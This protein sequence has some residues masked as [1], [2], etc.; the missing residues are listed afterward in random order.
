MSANETR[1][2]GLY[3]GT[4]IGIVLFALVGLL[5]GSMIGGVAGLKIAG[6]MLGAPLQGTLFARLIVAA[7]MIMGVLVAAVVFIFGMG[8]LGWIGGSVVETLR[9]KRVV[10]VEDQLKSKKAV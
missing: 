8:T 4:G 10:A 7:G 5:P 3:I 1:K 2:K 6:M 9:M